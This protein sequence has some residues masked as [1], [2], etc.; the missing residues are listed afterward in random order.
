[1][2]GINLS[3]FDESTVDKVYRLLELL[4]EMERHPVLTVLQKTKSR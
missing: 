4:E 2:G 1:M 3:E